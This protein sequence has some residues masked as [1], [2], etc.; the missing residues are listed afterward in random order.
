MYT[1]NRN[2]SQQQPHRQPKAT[3]NLQPKQP[4]SNPNPSPQTAKIPYLTT[5]IPPPTMTTIRPFTYSD[6]LL[7][8]RAGLDAVFRATRTALHHA[9]RPE[10]AATIA[11][12]VHSHMYAVAARQSCFVLESG[13]GEVAGYILGTPHTPQFVHRFKNCTRWLLKT[14]GAEGIVAPP[15]YRALKMA[16]PHPAEDFAAYLLHSALSRTSGLFGAGMP[17]LWEK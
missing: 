14:L 1:H 12:Y 6:K 15:N 16:E 8:D 4:S 11:A 2:D 13:A 7:C 3:T 9:F 17:G 10:P 5:P